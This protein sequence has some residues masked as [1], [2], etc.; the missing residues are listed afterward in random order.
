M[1]L[2]REPALLEIMNS[3]I[4]SNFLRKTEGHGRD[5]ELFSNLHKSQSFQ[6]APSKPTLDSKST[7][8]NADIERESK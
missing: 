1:L 7:L 8:N 4:E 2:S 6:P 5:E 3:N